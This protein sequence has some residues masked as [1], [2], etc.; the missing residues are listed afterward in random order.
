MKLLITAYNS[1]HLK[2]DHLFSIDIIA[3]FQEIKRRLTLVQQMVPQN[4]P[5]QNL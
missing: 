1:N 3:T 4:E 2:A 5:Q